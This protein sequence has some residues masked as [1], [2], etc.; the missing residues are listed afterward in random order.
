MSLRNQPD[1]IKP[2]PSMF[3]FSPWGTIDEITHA[4]GHAR[5][6]HPVFGR[7]WRVK[8]FVLIEEVLELIWAVVWERDPK[9]IKAEALD[10]IAVLVRSVEGD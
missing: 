5:A 10:C 7:T 8:L 6:K 3:T 2:A 4:V 9:R 1:E